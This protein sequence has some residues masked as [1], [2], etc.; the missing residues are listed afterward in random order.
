MALPHHDLLLLEVLIA[1]KIC[2]YWPFEFQAVP[3][4]DA[5]GNTVAIESLVLQNEDWERDTSVTEPT[6]T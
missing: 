4:M 6:G 5:S 3:D 1:W 2:R